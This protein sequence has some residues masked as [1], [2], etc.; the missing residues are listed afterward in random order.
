[1]HSAWDG[2]VI[3]VSR[4]SFLQEAAAEVHASLDC[5]ESLL[6]AHIP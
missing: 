6:M 1:M 3:R 2:V 4:V 5:S